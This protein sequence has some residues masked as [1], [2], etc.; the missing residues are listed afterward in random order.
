MLQFLVCQ[1]FDFLLEYKVVFVD[2]LLRNVGNEINSMEVR[3]LFELLF[4]EFFCSLNDFD[5][6]YFM[7]MDGLDESEC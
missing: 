1:L 4:E 3:D 2:K 6:I 5:L 7:V